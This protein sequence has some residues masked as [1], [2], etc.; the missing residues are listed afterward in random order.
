ML[1]ELCARRLGWRPEA[2]QV[3]E[4]F[5]ASVA[6]TRDGLPLV[7]PVPGAAGVVACC[8]F[9]LRGLSLALPMGEAVARL[10]VEGEQ[11]MPRCFLPGRLL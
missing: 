1:G 9:N 2:E 6:Q 8:G 5:G 3:A 10:I 4:R 11:T 7:G